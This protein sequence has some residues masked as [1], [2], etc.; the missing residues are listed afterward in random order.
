MT[1]SEANDTRGQEPPESDSPVLLLRNTS[2]L[3]E[4]MLGSLGRSGSES[5]ES[6]EPDWTPIHLDVDTTIDLLSSSR[7]REIIVQLDDLASD[8]LTTVGDL[9]TLIGAVEENCAPD[10]VS[11]GKL[12]D[13]RTSLIHRHL[14]TLRGHDVVTYDAETEIVRPGESV[15]ELTDLI[16]AIDSRC[17]E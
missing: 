4:R 10:Q 5:N 8:E 14:V 16:I 11:E 12:E 6:Y 1:A 7:R 17:A 15:S 13:I 9:A 3:L 2:T